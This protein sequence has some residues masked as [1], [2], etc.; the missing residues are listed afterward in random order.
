LNEEEYHNQNQKN[1]LYLVMAHQTWSQGSKGLKG[2]M[3]N[4]GIET[5]FRLGRF[6]AE[7]QAAVLLRPNPLLIKHEVAD[8]QAKERS[9]PTFYSLTE[10]HEAM[11]Q[12]IQTLKR[13][14]QGRPGQAFVRDSE[15]TVTKITM[16]P[17]PTPV[18][19]PGLYAAVEEEY[20]QR[21]FQPVEAVTDQMAS[22]LSMRQATLRGGVLLERPRS[23][24]PEHAKHRSD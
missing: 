19:D 24:R 15:G 14:Y 21:Y 10:Q 3:Q 11:V 23:L 22:S 18:I 6:D 4:C 13:S 17:S 2:A 8:T 12:Q 1:S 5:V 7:Y 16:L 20:L 9:H